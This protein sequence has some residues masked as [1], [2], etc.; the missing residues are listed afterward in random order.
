ML[1]LLDAAHTP[2]VFGDAVVGLLG[3]APELEQGDDHLRRRRG[4]EPL[5]SRSRSTCCCRSTRGSWRGCCARRDRDGQARLEL[6]LLRGERRRRDRHPGRGEGDLAESV[7][8]NQLPGTWTWFVGGLVLAV[9]ERVGERS[10]RREPWPVRFATERPLA[11]WGLAFA[12]LTLAAWAVGLAARPVRA[13]SASLS[14]QAQHVLYA[15][16]AF[17]LVAPM[18]FHDGRRSLPATLLST[19]VLAWLGPD[20]LR[21]LPLPPAVRVRVPGHAAV[22]AVRGD[23]ALHGARDRGGDGRAPRPATTWSSGRCCGSRSRAG[24]ARSR[25][26]AHAVAAKSES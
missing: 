3:P 11:C 19:R 2:G 4:L 25:T 9:D 6:L 18:V 10:A 17:F 26:R 24:G 23:R 12:C 1:G 7:F 15:G 22:A 20:L 5:A 8:G 13:A 14:L 16:T 21:D